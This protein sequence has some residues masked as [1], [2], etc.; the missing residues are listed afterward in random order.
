MQGILFIIHICSGTDS[1]DEEPEIAGVPTVTA[2][3]T[4]GLTSGYNY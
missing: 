2:T 3:H 4:S 1:S